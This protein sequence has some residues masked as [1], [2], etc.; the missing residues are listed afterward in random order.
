[1]IFKNIMFILRVVS[2][3][4]L[5]FLSFDSQAQPETTLKISYK[6]EPILQGSLDGKS[7]QM[8]TIVSKI[9]DQAKRTKYILVTNQKEATFRKEEMMSK[10]DRNPYDKIFKQGAS[11]FTGFHEKLYSN[12]QDSEI[13]FK[14]NLAGQ[15]LVVKRDFYDFKWEIKKASQVILGLPTKKA[16]GIYHNPISGNSHKI[17]AWFVPSIPIKTGPDIYNGLP[18]LILEL[19]LPKAVITA[20]TIEESEKL[21]IKK[22]SYKDALSQKEYEKLISKLNKKINLNR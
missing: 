13:I 7:E 19:E 17:I 15:E 22:I 8:K 18:G 21:E 14:Q 3:F 6:T 10:G 20:E 4:C 2:C 11:R 12:N 1:M 9:I 5:L 16:E